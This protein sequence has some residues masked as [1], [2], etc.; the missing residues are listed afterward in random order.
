MIM[1]EFLTVVELVALEVTCDLAALK[2]AAIS[3]E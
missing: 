2:F 3:V 1:L